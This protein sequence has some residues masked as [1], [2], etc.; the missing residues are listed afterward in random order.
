MGAYSGALWMMLK[1][2]TGAPTES[3]DLE[4]GGGVKDGGKTGHLCSLTSP[5]E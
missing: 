1:R 5:K 4:V 3:E 2:G